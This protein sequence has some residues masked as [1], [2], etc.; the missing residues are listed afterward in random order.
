MNSRALTGNDFADTTSQKKKKFEDIKSKIEDQKPRFEE[1]QGLR[2]DA[3]GNKTSERFD[4]KS[5]PTNYF[6]VSVSGV[7]ESGSVKCRIIPLNPLGLKRNLS[8]MQI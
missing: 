8:P 7:V 5:I 3:L 4:P 6:Y 2:A 1:Q